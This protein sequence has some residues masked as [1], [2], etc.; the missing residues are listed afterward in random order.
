[1]ASLQAILARIT[2]KSIDLLD[3]SEVSRRLKMQGSSERGLQ[4]IPLDAIVGSVSRYAD[5]TKNFLPRQSRDEDRW[6]RVKTSILHDPEGLKPI[7]VYKIGEAYFVKDGH[8]RVSIASGMGVKNIQA[9]VTEIRTLVPIDANT[10]PDELILKTE[11]AD[12]LANTQVDEILPQAD[13]RITVPGG[14]QKLEEHIRVHRFFMGVDQHREIPWDEAV[15]HWY[16]FVYVPVVNAIQERGVL[17]EFPGRSETDLYLWI[18][19]YRYLLEK[20]VG[21]EIRSDVAAEGLTQKQSPRYSRVFKRFWSKFVQKVT[22]DVLENAPRTGAW[23]DAKDANNDCLF[24][25]ILVPVS[26]EAESW[27]ALDEAIQITRCTGMHI[28][29]LHVVGTAEEASAGRIAQ[30]REKFETICAQTG[31]SG[32]FSVAVGEISNIILDRVLLND[33]MVLNVAHPPSE[34]KFARLSSG[35]RTILRRSARPILAVPGESR[36]LERLLLAYDG[37]L[38]SR[39]ALFLSA[40]LACRW[41]LQLSVVTVRNGKNASRLLDNAREYLSNRGIRPECHLVKG[42]ESQVILNIARQ[43]NSSLVLMGGYGFTPVLEVVLGST[44][45][46]VLRE[47]EIPVLICQ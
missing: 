4:D 9:Y 21:W 37:S 47:A 2:G 28:N 45:D 19:E 20:E 14:Y 7:E 17:K 18:S 36:A 22:P 8:H 32:A 13:F 30:I 23:L 40:Y 24:S 39:E 43:E 29:G 31:Y 5:F 12:F 38:K 42:E 33:V 15:R 1:M 25:D 10:S 26:G 34:N 11:F 46:A 35:M 44:V 6:A 27:S 41:N 16:E 3:F